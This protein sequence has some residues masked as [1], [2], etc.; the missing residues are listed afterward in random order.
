MVACGAN[1]F[2]LETE[3][4]NSLPPSRAGETSSDSAT[5]VDVL[6]MSLSYNA[7][8]TR[9]VAEFVFDIFCDETRPQ[10]LELILEVFFE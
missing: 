10:G 6:I 5:V 2:P 4:A 7:S 9:P 1:V 3:L 8:F